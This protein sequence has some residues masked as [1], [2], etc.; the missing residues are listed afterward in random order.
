MEW[1]W[2]DWTL[3]AIAAV[4]VAAAIWEGLIREL[5]SIAS[6]V[7]GLVIAVFGYRTGG[8]WFRSL[9]DLPEVALGLGFLA[10][11]FGTL[12]VGALA[13]FLARKIVQKSGLLWFD[14]FLGGLFGLVRGFAICSV[15]LMAMVAFSIRTSAVQ[16]STLT[17]YV[18]LGAR[19]VGA[20][21]PEGIRA[22][23]QNGVDKFKRALVE[24][25]R[26][27]VGK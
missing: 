13:A 10:L 9:T 21:M 15:L 7:I 22:R 1:N 11:F 23:F 19:A 24:K 18:V 27:A 14:R 26:K 5:I 25:D 16:N 3:S 17:P 8:N 20:L 6:L 2:L 4:S 12:V